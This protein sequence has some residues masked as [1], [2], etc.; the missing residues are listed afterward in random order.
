MG[1]ALTERLQRQR[2]RAWRTLAR[3]EDALWKA[4]ELGMSSSARIVALASI[5]ADGHGLDDCEEWNRV[6]KKAEEDCAK[7]LSED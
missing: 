3:V 2:D 4:E 5:L 1:E 7:N 6:I